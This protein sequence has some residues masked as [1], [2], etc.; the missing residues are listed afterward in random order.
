M[1]S[2]NKILDPTDPPTS[3]QLD[4]GVQLQHILIDTT[5]LSPQESASRI[6][7]AIT[8]DSSDEHMNGNDWVQ[9]YL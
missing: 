8:L 3:Y 7:D 4:L 5:L 6:L 2:N 9:R 1:I